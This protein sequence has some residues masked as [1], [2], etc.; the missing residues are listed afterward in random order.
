MS[1]GFTGVRPTMSPIADVDPLLRKAFE[2]GQTSLVR[3]GL[4]P[5]VREIPGP[6]VRPARKDLKSGVVEQLFTDDASNRGA[7]STRLFDYSVRLRATHGSKKTPT[8][9]YFTAWRQSVAEPTQAALFGTPTPGNDVCLLQ[10]VSSAHPVDPNKPPVLLAAGTGDNPIRAFSAAAED[11]ASRGFPVYFFTPN[12]PNNSATVVAEQLSVAAE[13]IAHEHGGTLPIFDG[14]SAANGPVEVLVRLREP[15]FKE[16]LAK[17]GL[18]VP[19]TPLPPGKVKILHRGHPGLGEDLTHAYS[20]LVAGSLIPSFATN[21]SGFSRLGF[22]NLRSVDTLPNNSSADVFP[23]SSSLLARQSAL[24]P[25]VAAAIDAAFHPFDVTRAAAAG[26]LALQPLK[27]IA[28]EGGPGF[29][30]FSRGIDAAAK[31]GGNLIELFQ[32][33]PTK[34]D[35]VERHAIYGTNPYNFNGSRLLLEETLGESLVDAFT[36]PL[37]YTASALAFS[38]WGFGAALTL[39]VSQH[40]LQG[41]LAG[42]FVAGDLRGGRFGGDG[43]VSAKSARGVETLGEVENLIELDVAHL[44]LIRLDEGSVERAEQVYR[45]NPWRNAWAKEVAARSRSFNVAE[46]MAN[47]MVD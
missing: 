30:A 35:Q 41:M 39:G 2:L 34:G 31:D 20:G 36:A 17:R 19:S 32:K 10:R 28:Y 1:L 6:K 4:P 14:H 23:G 24:P 45:E 15:G 5:P 42:Q 26:A 25:A 29:F 18:F 33:F 12:N 13:F 38:P 8:P 46:Y 16:E 43:V 3:G 47:H 37:D 27:G 40:Q 22:A 11:F 44:D 7:D 9:N 21:A